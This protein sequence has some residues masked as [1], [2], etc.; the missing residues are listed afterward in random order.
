MI[1][2][3]AAGTAAE[4]NFERMGKERR[5]TRLRKS[6]SLDNNSKQSSG[7]N[8]PNQDRGSIELGDEAEK[9]NYTETDSVYSIMTQEDDETIFERCLQELISATEQMSIIRAKI[10]IIHNVAV[11]IPFKM[12][13]KT[14]ISAA[15]MSLSEIQ[16]DRL[17][18]LGLASPIS[19]AQL[20]LASK[21]INQFFV[22]VLIV[23]VVL[24]CLETSP[25]LH[26]RDLQAIFIVECFCMTVFVVEI[27]T[28]ALCLQRGLFPLL[29]DSL[30]PT[31]GHVYSLFEVIYTSVTIEIVK[32][33]SS[34]L[35]NK[36]SDSVLAIESPVPLNQ[37]IQYRYLDSELSRWMW[38]LLDILAT[39]P[40]FIELLINVRIVVSSKIGYFE[41]IENMYSW[42]E[43]RPEIQF[44]RLFRVARLF[45][46]GQKSDKGFGDIT[47]RSSLGRIVI[48]IVMF[49]AFF[50]VAFPLCIITME[51]SHY[52]RIFS[53]KK[54]GHVEDANILRNRLLLGN[55]AS[56]SPLPPPSPLPENAIINEHASENQ[57][58][59]SNEPEKSQL[60]LD[61][62]N[63][64]LT[65]PDETKQVDK[66][67][68]QSTPQST[69]VIRSAG[70]HLRSFTPPIR[71]F[72]S[73][74]LET[75]RI[76]GITSHS[77]SEYE[78]DDDMNSMIHHSNSMSNI[79]H[80]E[81]L[82]SIRPKHGHHGRHQHNSHHHHH[83][84]VSIADIDHGVSSALTD[85]FPNTI[86]FRIRDWKLEYKEEKR[87]DL[88]T[89]RIRVKDEKSYRELLKL[90][91]EH[92]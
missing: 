13:D 77:A 1:R 47:P 4:S 75:P 86:L 15:H 6:P 10:F 33:N 62:K 17:T 63:N 54:R 87:E 53:E 30:K 32:L 68:Q 43:G 81:S 73:P 36:N 74:D 58:V 72:T 37:V 22:L 88:L 8:T 34:G 59:P 57:P 14:I 44:L 18:V 3:I 21:L 20:L 92:C 65:I 23:A 31:F 19:L 49:L 46:V 29:K 50:V 79:P 80:S 11:L 89:M 82:Y 90:L 5:M 83:H 48:S 84:H 76:I 9:D 71:S 41:F 26:I 2:S 52:A 64:P 16:R 67:W 24:L 7:I 51:Y 35:S 25:S 78:A 45:K 60:A 42:A 12:I 70:N 91:A 55:N 69:N 61:H 85:G 56:D 39:L 40:F 27:I 66:L 38:L 28:Q